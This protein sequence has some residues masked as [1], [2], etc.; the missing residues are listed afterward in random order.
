MM[1]LRK[2][3][4]GC[5]CSVA[6]FVGG[7]A[8]A[9][10]VVTYRY[11]ALG[12]LIVSTIAGGPN[13]AVGTATCFDPAGNRTRYTVGSGVA[14]CGSG[15]TPTPTPSPVPTN[16]AP[17]AVG[18]AIN[19][20]CNAYVDYDVL[21]NDHDPDGNAPLSLVSVTGTGNVDATIVNA[22][23]IRFIG[24]GLGTDGLSYVVQDALGATATGAITYHTTGT[25]SICNQ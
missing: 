2:S 9:S 12:R 10:E 18:D 6:M 5:S 25:Q 23:T 14:S 17:V 20:Q 21:A 19:G 13:D 8:R 1:R 7:V 24:Y 3:L 16:Q 15:A 4:L 11:D 22:T